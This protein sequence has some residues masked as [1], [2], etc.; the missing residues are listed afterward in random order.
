MPVN[1][2]S[3]PDPQ[4]QRTLLITAV[5]LI[6]AAVVIFAFFFKRAGSSGM[7]REQEDKLT[8]PLQMPLTSGNPS[9]TPQAPS[10]P[11]ATPTLPRAGQ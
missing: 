4:R 6:V 2:S 1:A 9:L 3:T 10:G 11:N 8:A 5:V 7:T